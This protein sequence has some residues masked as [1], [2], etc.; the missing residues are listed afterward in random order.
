MIE[1]AIR[2]LNKYYGSNHVIK[3]ISIEIM[4]GE[5]IGLLGKNGTGKSTLFKI[6]AGIEDFEEGNITRAGDGKI[7]LLEQIPVFKDGYSVE[8]V[9]HDAFSEITDIS[10][11]MRHLEDLITTDDADRLLSRYGSLQA[12][13]EARGGYELESRIDRICTGMKIG[14]EMR[15]QFFK[16]LSGGE[17]TRVNLA[18]ILLRDSNVLLLDEPT[19]HLDMSSLRWLEDFL[20]AFQGTAVIISHDRCLLDNVVE[21]IIEIDEGKASFYEGNYSFYAEEK[22]RRFQKQNQE[23]ELQQRKIGQLEAASKRMHEWARNADNPAMHKRAFS[24]EKRIERI[25]RIDKPIMSKRIASEFKEADFSSREI[26][27][28]RGIRKAY[29]E[30]ILF[31]EVNLKIMRKDRIAVIGSNGCGK[32]SFLKL[33]AGGEMPDKGEV[34]ISSSIKMAIMPQTIEFENS[35]ATVLETFRYM[36]EV[37]EERARSILT[38]FNFRGKD[39]FKKTGILSGGEKS[40]LKL[41]ILMQSECN[42][43]LLDEPTNHMDIESREWIEKAISLYKGT[44]VFVSHDRYFLNRFAERIFDVGNGRITD[45]FGTYGE[46]CNWKEKAARNSKQSSEKTEIGGDIVEAVKVSNKGRI[47][48]HERKITDIE[49]QITEMENKLKAISIEMDSCMDDFVKLNVLFNEK[50]ELGK[51]LEILYEEWGIKCYE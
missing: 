39:V 29:G 50:S 51:K 19:N 2:D 27:S 48:I 13:Y 37:N 6:I 17:K 18:R 35:E 7:E 44:M 15:K 45:F 1:I 42:L 22:E 43:L 33:I 12:E 3:G 32:T 20:K 16:D 5:K 46:Y 11:E 28:L 26:V 21:R 41:C 30:K 24:I 4:K 47:D 10:D 14:S 36:F 40:R 8:D 31:D 9:L 23:Y 34:N 38:V 49:N 25:E